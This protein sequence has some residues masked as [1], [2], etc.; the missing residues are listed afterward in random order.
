MKHKSLTLNNFQVRYN[1]E[2]AEISITSKDPAL[3]KKPFILN[4][5]GDSPTYDTLLELLKQEGLV[6]MDKTRISKSIVIPDASQTDSP[7]GDFKTRIRIGETFLDKPVE[8][9]LA[10]SP[11]T[12]V[13]GVAGGGK[14][15]FQRLVAAHALLHKDEIDFYAID[16]KRVEL[17]SYFEDSP[18]RLATTLDDALNL[19]EMLKRSIQGRYDLL[20]E[21][22]KT[23]IAGM[24]KKAVYLMV[25]DLG[26]LLYESGERTREGRLEDAKR[27]LIQDQLLYLARLGRSVGVYLFIGTQ[28]PDSEIIPGELNSL[29]S[30]RILMGSAGSQAAHLA[31]AGRP[32][33]GG[34]LLRIPGRA[35]VSIL[36]KQ[37]LTQIYYL[38]FEHVIRTKYAGTAPPIYGGAVPA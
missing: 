27:I 9:D 36:G 32:E 24:G 18:E 33:F 22:G 19:L 37:T 10:N 31:L 13:T 3:K 38:N 5:S 28:R 26:T 16:L 12:L 4:L 2:T 21:A 6:D 29:F 30:N 17:K 34:G 1:P 14:S 7:Q 15:V 20:E 8:L 35:I 25:D 11:H 23:S